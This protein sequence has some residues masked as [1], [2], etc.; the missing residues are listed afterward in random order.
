MA[1]RRVHG[2]TV[3]KWLGNEVEVTE[4][5]PVSRPNPVPRASLF[6]V[7]AL[8]FCST[9]AEEDEQQGGNSGE[10]CLSPSMPASDRRQRHHR[11]DK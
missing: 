4:S 9:I 8:H 2:L 11:G 5:S 6:V 10:A 7:R 3:S 1:S